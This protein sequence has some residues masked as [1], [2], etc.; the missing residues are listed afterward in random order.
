MPDFEPTGQPLNG[1]G[2]GHQEWKEF[3][4]SLKF[5]Q[6][7]KVVGHYCLE[8]DVYG[9]G[10]YVPLALAIIHKPNYLRRLCMRVFL[11]FVWRDTP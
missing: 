7:P 3:T 1:A 4:P 10:E 8:P 9:G 11:G 5:I 6:A 2:D